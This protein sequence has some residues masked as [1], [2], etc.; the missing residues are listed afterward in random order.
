MNSPFQMSRVFLENLGIRRAPPR[1]WPGDTCAGGHPFLPNRAGD[2]VN[3]EATLNQGRDLAEDAAGYASADLSDSFQTCANCRH[4]YFRTT[5]NE[6]G[7]CRRCELTVPRVRPVRYE[8]TCVPDSTKPAYAFRRTVG[9]N[10]CRGMH[11]LPDSWTVRHHYAGT[12]LNTDGK[13]DEEAALT[14][15]WLVAHTFATSEEALEHAK[16]CALFMVG[17][18]A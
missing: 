10:L 17:T 5:D 16:R 3:C 15:E 8:V 11:G 4:S 1:D 14:K 6:S 2:C 13:W 9:V 18:H 7:V 12:W